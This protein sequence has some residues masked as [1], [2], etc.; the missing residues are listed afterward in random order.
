MPMTNPSSDSD[1]ND[2]GE[3]VSPK[4][5]HAES[6]SRLGG[7]G[8]RTFQN[9]ATLWQ[10]SEKERLLALG[11]PARST[12]H[13]WVS[14]AQANGIIS[15]PLDTLLR[16]S[17]MLG[18]HKNLRVLFGDSGRGAQWLRAENTAPLFGGQ[19]PVDLITSGTQ[20]GILEVRRFLDS[21]RG[22]IFSAPIDHPIE[23]RAWSDEEIEIIDA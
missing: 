3:I 2:P 19:R 20:T 14:K 22:G 9:I 12:Y 18:I 6:R 7:P 10:L 13:S 8:L 4:T 15:L 11:S 1:W 23:D 16:I 5:F 21:W 17:A